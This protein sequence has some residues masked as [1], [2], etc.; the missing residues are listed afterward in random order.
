VDDLDDLD[1]ISEVPPE[2]EH[3]KSPTLCGMEVAGERTGHCDGAACGYPGEGCCRNFYGIKSWD[4]HYVMDRVTSTKRC[5][6]DSALVRMG[7]L[8]DGPHN[9]WRLASTPVVEGS[10]EEAE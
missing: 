5:H 3:P 2:E 6:S 8:H 1:L 10:K 9:S 7:Y 4:K